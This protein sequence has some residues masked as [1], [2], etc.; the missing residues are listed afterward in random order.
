MQSWAEIVIDVQKNWFL[1]ASMP[2]VAAIIGYVTKIVAIRM[3]FQPIE[4][5]GIKPPFLGWQG[6]V[7]RKAA[8]MAS[9]ACDTMTSKLIKPSD[10]FD[11]LDP[12][13]IA[14]EIEKPLLEAVED[15]TREVA[16]QYAP[17]L[18]EA[19]PE[20][21]KRMIISRIQEEAP[22]IVKQIMLDIKA[23]INSVFDLKD[24]VVSN[25]LRDKPLLNRIFLEAGHGE[26]RF[27]RNSGLFFGFAIG[28]VQAVVWA[29]TQ[30]VWVM[31]LFG[32]FTGWFTDWLALKMIFN[33]K[34]PT[35]YLGG[36]FTWQGL[37]LKR[38]LEVS[39]EYGRLIAAEIVTP[40]N[41]I[42]AVLRGPLSDRL[43]GMVQK[44]VQR[45][46]DA[47]S[48]VAKPF[49]VLAVG[50]T[51]YQDMKRLVSTEIMKRL[52]DT[53]KHIEKYAHDAM[54]LERTLATKMQDL[55]IEEFENLLHP[56]FEQ[57]EWILIAVGAVL[58]FMVGELQVHV[59]LHFAA[60]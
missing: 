9:I 12:D 31:P 44:Q 46:V 4:F 26:F 7:P 48:G 49:V 5:I 58:G 1:Y 20:A 38:R 11:R 34:Q 53:M 36:L 37:F 45:V 54:D 55:S 13:R 33:P 2:F 59:M 3:M 6:I 41:I 27:I 25:L 32:G 30:N 56:A 39:A 21:V 19:A 50:S 51:K 16:E 52:P 22:E 29:L 57:D 42:D 28:C 43:F 35:K 15:I 47:Q 18:W 14:E 60:H 17:G 8:I 10:I 23:N 40:R 24:M